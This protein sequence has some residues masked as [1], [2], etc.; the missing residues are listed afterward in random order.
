M[1]E[2]EFTLRFDVSRLTAKLE[3]C[4]EILAAHGC[5]DA[6]I[7]IGVPGRIGLIFSREAGSAEDA[8]LSALRDVSTALPTAILV[9]ATPDLVGITEVAEIVGKSRQNMRKLL[10]ECGTGSPLP[11]HEGSSSIWHL[12]PVLTW[13]RDEKRYSIEQGLLDL[14]TTNMQINAASSRI[15]ISPRVQEDVELYLEI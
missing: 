15:D 14:A 4:V 12:A 5:A 3:D 2:Y 1:N 11:V 7:G 13:L 10:L 8:V 9:E 6:T